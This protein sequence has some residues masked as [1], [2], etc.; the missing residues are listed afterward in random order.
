M[1]RS[2]DDGDDG[3]GLIIRVFVGHITLHGLRASLASFTLHDYITS[4]NR[5]RGLE[6]ISS[7]HSLHSAEFY[8]IAREYPNPTIP[9]SRDLLFL[10]IRSVSP[11]SSA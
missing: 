10:F 11:R 6:G 1:L 3:D 4:K 5:T 8:L 7:I 9:S 2:F